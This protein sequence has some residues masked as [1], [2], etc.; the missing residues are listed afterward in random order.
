MAS[1]WYCG[2][3]TQFSSLPSPWCRYILSIDSARELEDYLLELLNPEDESHLQFIKELIQRWKPKGA[4]NA[5]V[6]VYQKEKEEEVG[7][8]LMLMPI[9]SASVMFFLTN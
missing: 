7:S 5:N 8:F 4:P 2:P 6:T 1:Q 3:L 9:L